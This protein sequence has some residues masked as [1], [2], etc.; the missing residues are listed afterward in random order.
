MPPSKR[1]DP[2]DLFD[3]K[4]PHTVPPVPQVVLP[5]EEQRRQRIRLATIIGVVVILFLV[6]AAL[7][8]TAFNDRRLS[9]AID[10]ATDEGRPSQIARA[11]DL[12]GDS[13][14]GVRARLL[15]TAAFD[16]DNVAL[17]QAESILESLQGSEDPDSKVARIFVALAKGN[18]VKAKELAVPGTYDRQASEFLRARALSSLAHGQTQKALVDTTD[19]IALR[20]EAPRLL[21]AHAIVIGQAQGGQAALDALKDAPDDVSLITAMRARFMSIL[22]QSAEQAEQLATQVLTEQDVTARDKSWAQITMAR[23]AFSRGSLF[24]SANHAKSAT[25]TTVRGDEQLLLSTAVRLLLL[26]ENDAAE[27]TLRRLVA[28]PSMDATKRALL[29]AWLQIANGNRRAAINMLAEA[30]IDQNKAAQ[31]QSL[32]SLVMAKI[33]RSSNHKSDKARA[34]Q[35]F[36]LAEKD[37]ELFIY[38]TASRTQLLN[39]LGRHQEALASA[40]AGLQNAANHPLLVAQLVE[41]QSAQGNVATALKTVAQAIKAHPE[42]PSLYAKRGVLLLDVGK[43]NEAATAYG[44]ASELAPQN[45]RYLAMHGA[46][47]RLIGNQGAARNA[48]DNAL[49]IA[50]RNPDA[51]VGLLRLALDAHNLK[52]AEQRMA[53]IDAAKL[54]TAATDL[55]RACYLVMRNAG[56][57]GMKAVR[58][59]IVRNKKESR[60]RIA[61]A[62][63]SLQAEQYGQ[64]ALFYSGVRRAGGDPRTSYL[65]MA[66]SYSYDRKFRDAQKALKSALKLEQPPTQAQQSTLDVVKGRIEWMLNNRSAAKKL[67]TA[68]VQRTPTNAHAHLLL[69]DIAGPRKDVAISHLRFAANAPAPMSIAAGQ[70][71]LRLGA[72]K[73]GCEMAN[74]YLKAAARGKLSDRVSALKD[75]CNAER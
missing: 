66:L 58:S 56:A 23:S 44:K 22:P 2:T 60:L 48:F 19:A 53:A 32:G 13:E 30:N 20:P 63:L 47:L 72:T 49:E 42:E 27:K 12:L 1:K 62:D 54:P 6:V 36:A 16:G 35:R 43:T 50:N 45:P 15:A 38:S 4:P 7:T 69:A 52:D 71:A 59:A 67:A 75:R 61:A 65:G 10:R 11:I 51:L 57:T 33:D 9:N 8:K 29:L 68:A 31:D 46:T 18:A 34:I 40:Q 64:A 14:P 24:K 17:G 21:A 74:T 28:G 55:D 70:L 37:P 39:A 41:A 73:E 5:P 3:V 25:E 26:R